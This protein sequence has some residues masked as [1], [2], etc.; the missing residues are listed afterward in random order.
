MSEHAAQFHEEQT[1]RRPWLLAT[2][3]LSTFVP[4]VAVVGA[5]V[6]QVIS[7]R[8]VGNNPISTPALAAVSA[9]VL[10]VCGGVLGILLFSRLIV[11]VRGDALRIRFAPFHRRFVEIPL[12]EIA[13]HA[14]RRYRPIGE[15]GGWGIRGLARNRAYNVRG[16]RGV[17]L[18][19]R[20]GR[21]IL[22]GS[23]RADDLAAAISRAITR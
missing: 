6:L 21:K 17:Q 15:Y 23:Q 9:L 1:F 8:P 13:S 20:D 18:V 16:D 19:L 7:G 5:L 3:G 14:A 4:I 11:E 22:I 10:L 2:L 12:A